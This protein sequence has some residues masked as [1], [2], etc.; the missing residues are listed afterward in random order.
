M[1]ITTL[2]LE[3]LP[4]QTL[5]TTQDQTRYSITL[6]DIG[7]TTAATIS[8]NEVEIISGLGV[9]AGALL[10]PYLYLENGNFTFVTTD[11]TLPVYTQFGIDQFL[12]YI[13]QSDLGA[14]RG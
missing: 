6:K 11:G 12:I 10:I 7:G 9:V 14:G 3:A 13:P 8:I 4:S 1:T 5:T 2:P